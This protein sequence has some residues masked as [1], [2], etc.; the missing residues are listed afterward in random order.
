MIEHL[1][2]S[3]CSSLAMSNWR[4]YVTNLHQVGFCCC[5]LHRVRRRPSANTKYLPKSYMVL[6]SCLCNRPIETAV[7]HACL[8]KAAKQTPCTVHETRLSAS[9]HCHQ[10]TQCSCSILYY[11]GVCSVSLLF[12][13]LQDL[14]ITKVNQMLLTCHAWLQTLSLGSCR[15]P[16]W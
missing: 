13:T 4:L 9:C 3:L 15:R 7:W 2:M 5:C 10:P 6:S 1:G 11:T 16:L 8:A 12:W 14:D